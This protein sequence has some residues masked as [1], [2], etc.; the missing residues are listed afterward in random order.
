MTFAV[1]PNVGELRGAEF[2][3]GITY[4]VDAQES[5]SGPALAQFELRSDGTIWKDE[6]DGGATQLGTWLKY[7]SGADY[8]VMGS[9]SWTNAGSTGTYGGEEAYVDLATTRTWTVAVSL[10]D[11]AW[12]TWTLALRDKATGYVLDTQAVTM[13]ATKI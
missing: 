11:A 8:E 5:A 1:R 12:G 3:S 6:D 10:S 4:D 7:G 9:F 2:P 13:M